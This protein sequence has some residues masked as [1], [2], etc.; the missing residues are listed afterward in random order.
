MN[1]LHLAVTALSLNLALIIPPV[2]AQ[3]PAP[4]ASAAPSAAIDPA[5]IDA[6]KRMG[7]YLR[8]LKAFQ[9]ESSTTDE[10]VLD[11]GQKLQYE[12]AVSFLAQMPDRL[13]VR[14]SSDRVER[15]YL[16][17]GKTIT[18]LAQRLNMYA[19]APAPPTTRQLID[20]LLDKY[21]I[22]V[23]L[24]DLFLWGAPGW[25]PD[26]IT[27]A[28]V[29]GPSVAGGA[30]CDQYAFRQ[31]DVDYQVWI[32]KGEFPLPRK[33]VITTKSDEARPQ[34]TAAFTWNLAPSFNDGAFA[35]DPPAGAQRVV[36]AELTAAK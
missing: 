24:A 21:G 16:Y 33:L 32:Q 3:V 20:V 1:R 17:D 6:L 27:G 10:L 12:S 18:L 30:T 13:R 9:V 26:A 19:T 7:A 11:D 35:L 28:M 36:L 14:Q 31:D 34:H 15:L 23:P 29:V 2:G 22:E 4:A 5:A 25:T 8:S